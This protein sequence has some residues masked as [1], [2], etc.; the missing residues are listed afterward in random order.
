MQGVDQGVRRDTPGIFLR[1][2]VLP[3]DGDPPFGSG[4]HNPVWVLITPTFGDGRPP[5]EGP[6]FPTGDRLDQGVGG[7]G[8]KT[9]PTGDHTPR[10][11][12]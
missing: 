12:Q 6:N 9:P 7:Q 10:R 5:P 11:A 3:M 8:A 1:R 4:A 2:G